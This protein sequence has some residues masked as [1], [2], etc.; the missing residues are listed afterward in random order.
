M[1]S[2]IFRAK[3]LNRNEK[4]VLFLTLWLGAAGSQIWTGTLALT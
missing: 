2:G 3:E 1:P 4:S